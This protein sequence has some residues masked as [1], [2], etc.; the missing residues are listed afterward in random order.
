MLPTSTTRRITPPLAA[1][2][3]VLILSTSHAANT[4]QSLG[5][6]VTPYGIS[7]DGM[8][9]A[10]SFIGSRTNGSRPFRWTDDTGVVD[11]S[12]AAD[13]FRAFSL[14]VAVSGNGLVIV[15]DSL[16][17]SLG[18]FRWTDAD[19]VASLFSTDP[20]SSPNA[21]SVAGSVVVGLFTTADANKNLVAFRWTSADGATS[22]GLLP[23]TSESC[24]TGV[25]ADGSV[26]VGYS[27][28]PMV[29]LFN[30]MAPMNPIGLVPG[31]SPFPNAPSD[32]QE[33]FR[34]T[35]AG[36]LVGLGFLPGGTLSRA[37]AVSADGA[38]VIG[39]SNG[40][41]FRWTQSGG[42]VAIGPHLPDGHYFTPVALSA[43]GSAIVGE[44]DGEAV[45]WDAIHGLQSIA[46]LLT[47]SGVDLAGQN[48]LSATGISADGTTI[49]GF[50][51]DASYSGQG[52][53]ATLTTIPNLPIS[54][55]AGTSE[56]TFNPAA[57]P[58]ASI[59]GRNAHLTNKTSLEING[60]AE[61]AVTQV[62][63]WVNKASQPGSPSSSSQP[64]PPDVA[65]GTNS[66]RFTARLKPGRNVITVIA[67][68][69][70]G[71]SAPAQVI[72]TRN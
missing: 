2:C 69:P 32:K 4:F 30:S 23:G 24:A 9:V 7:S 18:A 65:K 71:N 63:Y 26:V 58:L 27:Q 43:D 44:S 36:G 66:W 37:T 35:A 53:I 14:A 10:G 55:P 11:I 72:V 31:S 25:S 6:N 39:T 17:P 34:W 60:R 61:G 45:R 19:G 12:G 22:L 15:G 57:R 70:G 49:I 29:H 54:T 5:S 8:V 41:A 40:K 47:A 33:A 67:R 3:T 52:W 56:P 68:G 16:R 62:A 64:L 38:V 1:F 13:G 20:N 42:M 50:G 59:S 48:L 21:V 46:D 51:R 28:T